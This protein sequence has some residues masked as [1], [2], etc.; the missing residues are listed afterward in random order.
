MGFI[1]FIWHGCF[2]Y[3]VVF[4]LCPKFFHV[5]SQKQ[6][7]NARQHG[8][9]IW[10]VAIQCHRTRTAHTLYLILGSHTTKYVRKNNLSYVAAAAAVASIFMIGMHIGTMVRPTTNEIV[11]VSV[12][13][14]AHAMH[15]NNW[16]FKIVIVMVGIFVE[17]LPKSYS[18]CV[19]PF[20]CLPL[21]CTK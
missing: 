14:H 1:R 5:L 18:V 8:Y 4:L 12:L 20:A 6:C 9:L 13:K 15:Y 21:L 17:N 3:G 2:M 16:W 7:P 10:F 19:C 11:F